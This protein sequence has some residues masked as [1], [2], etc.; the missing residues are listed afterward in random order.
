MVELTPQQSHHSC[1]QNYVLVSV[2]YSFQ[3]TSINMFY[4]F[5]IC[6]RKVEGE[7]RYEQKKKHAMSVA[8]GLVFFGLETEVK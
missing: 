8:A 3:Y 1:F 7:L 2:I 4:M 5:A 6:V